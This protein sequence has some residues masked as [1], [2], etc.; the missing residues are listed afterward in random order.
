MVRAAVP[1]GLLEAGPLAAGWQDQR[2][3]LARDRDLVAGRFGVMY[4]VPGLVPA[5]LGLVVP[6]T[7]RPSATGPVSTISTAGEVPSWQT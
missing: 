5:A 4:T 1:A 2:W 3:M 7:H 6:C